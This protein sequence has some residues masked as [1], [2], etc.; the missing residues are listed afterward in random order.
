M[1]ARGRVEAMHV[2]V[3]ELP[4]SLSLEHAFE[5]MLCVVVDKR[6]RGQDSNT[7]HSAARL[8]LLIVTAQEAGA[9]WLVWS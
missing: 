6:L 3:S 4:D 9:T 2:K 8:L 5:T 7:R 1:W